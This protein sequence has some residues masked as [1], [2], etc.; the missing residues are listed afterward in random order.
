MIRPFAACAVLLLAL[1]ACSA[2]LQTPVVETT[3]TTS[4]A[5]SA[6]TTS[7]ATGGAT[8]RA[9]TADGVL[10]ALPDVWGEVQRAGG[11][12]PQLRTVEGVPARLRVVNYGEPGRQGLSVTV[13]ITA[14]PAGY[15][16][17]LRA[18]WA[19]P[20]QQGAASCGAAGLGLNQCARTLPDGVVS[21]GGQQTPAQLA[22]LAG[23]IARGTLR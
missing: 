17:A 12:T 1:P 22:E 2:P 11:P 19:K 18:T 10:G 3:S 8:A 14:D 4:T 9:L 5:A 7:S 13:A 23:V 6:A 20:S 21:V 16:D 15:V